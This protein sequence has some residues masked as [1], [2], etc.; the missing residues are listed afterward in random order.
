MAQSYDTGEELA[1]A[2]AEDNDTLREAANK[3]LGEIRQDGTFA[4]FYRKWF[5]KD[6]PKKILDGDPLALLAPGRGSP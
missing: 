5:R 6:P 4:R 3:T 2:F 1:M